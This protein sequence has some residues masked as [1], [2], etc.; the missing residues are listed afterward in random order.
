VSTVQ[1]FLE[2]TR[3]NPV[4]RGDS[5]ERLNRIRA[6]VIEEC[7]QKSYRLASIANIAKRAKV[8]TASLYRDF[9]NRENLLEQVAMF[10]TP[11]IAADFSIDHQGSTPQE[12]IQMLLMAQGAIY[13]NPHANWV[14]RAHISGEVSEGKGLLQVGR[15][16]RNQVQAFWENQI[17][18]LQSAGLIGDVDVRETVNFV[19]GSVQRRTLLAMLLFGLQDQAEPSP[20]IAASSA[21]EWI[22]ALKS[23]ARAIPDFTVP[24]EIHA[25]PS[26]I[27]TQIEADFGHHHDRTDALGRHQKILT[28]AALECSEVGFSQASVASVAKRANV[29]TATLYEHFHDKDD[30]FMKAVG[31]MVPLLTES[32]I[33][34]TTATNPCERIATMLVNHGASY[35]DPFMAWLFRLYV[36]VE[37]QGDTVASRLGKASRAMVEQFWSSQLTALEDQGYLSASDHIITVN[38][39]LGGVERRTLASFLLMGKEH[40]QYSQLVAA[41][42][43][44]A[45]TLFLRYGTDKFFAEFAPE[46]AVRAVA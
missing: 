34:A 10:T 32:V 44:G 42:K 9:G 3:A 16:T 30:M 19:L 38:L 31:Y 46:H 23:N 20:Q 27:Q 26:S 13:Q 15:D 41:A 33:R 6:A 40:A 22:M 43:H 2:Q 25:L 18:R 12:T 29:S 11:L 17:K 45:K 28:A 14:Y 8:S 36:S 39:L 37:G 4:T 7:A 1:K 35:L 24:N 5:G 21:I